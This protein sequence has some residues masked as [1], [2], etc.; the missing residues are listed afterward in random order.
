MAF[1]I[2][3]NNT[4]THHR[5]ALLNALRLVEKEE[6]FP[7][8]RVILGTKN[9][10]KS[11]IKLVFFGYPSIIC[12]VGFGRIY[13]DFGLFGK[14]V[15]WLIVKLVDVRSAIGFVVE[16][17]ED[18]TLLSDFVRNPVYFTHGSG[19]DPTG[20]EKKDKV[21]NK[22]VKIGYLSRFGKSKCSDQVL[23]A[24]KKMPQDREL[25]IAGWDINSKEYEDKFKS[26]ANKKENISFIGRL[27]GEKEVSKFFNEIDIF[28]TPSLREGGNISL[29]EAIW[30]S[31][32][33][34]TTEVAG[35]KVLAKEFDGLMCEPKFFGDLLVSDKILYHNPDLTKWPSK[36]D[37]YLAV[38]VSLEYYE[39]F[40]KIV[41]RL[42]KNFRS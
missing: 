11:T 40:L 2:N 3:H 28:I 33:F 23:A 19:L 13:T 6:K 22:R 16:N 30:H 41:N 37:P 42:N 26:L 17:D 7:L 18:Y 36:L 9:M 39:I 35:C 27:S 38:N 4:H 21:K 20:F 5:K 32:P 15:F 12:L 1:T 34:A 31:I 29:Q 25:I 8:L 10:I 24:A 14:F